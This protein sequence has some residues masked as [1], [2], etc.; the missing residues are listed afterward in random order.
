MDL[1]AGV[2]V[3]TSGVRLCLIDAEGTLVFKA[4][5]PL[6]KGR[7][8]G[9]RHEQDP[10]A[11]WLALSALL[12]AIPEDKA[13]QI[14]ALSLDGTSGSL[15]LADEQG[16]PLGPTLMYNDARATVEAKSIASHAPRESGAHGA[17]SSL[18]RLLWLMEHTD[19]SEVRYALHQADWLL[20]KLAGAY[21][22]SDENNCLKLG[23]DPVQRQWPEWINELGISTEWLPRVEEPGTA[24]GT[25]DAQIAADLG[26]PHDVKICTGTTDSIA[27]F[28]AT[29]A[30]AIGDAVTSLG[31]TLAIKVLSDRPV[32]APEYGVYSH[33]LWDRWLVGGASNSGGAVLLQHFT[34]EQMQALTEHLV[35]EIPSGLD[36]YPLPSKG[37]RFPVSDPELEPRLEPRPDV[38][39]RFFQ[40]LLE[41]IAHIEQQAYQKLHE[42]GAP[43]PHSLRT[44]GG[45]SHNPAWTQI[46]QQLLQIPFTQPQQEDAAYGAA[47]LARRGIMRPA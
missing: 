4:T 9:P 31:S 10:N 40:G 7:Q 15:L 29:G 34:P 22:F 3:G 8:D 43:W 26:L 46:R 11:W 17:S 13:Q 36:Y 12:K 28:L 23:Y 27:A 5:I 45:G 32:F 41:G 35:P 14:R 37:E 24:I 1:Y 47:L 25:I 6:P 30:S 2:D 33:R 16:Q 39:A 38:E 44:V 42:L 19:T 21:G 20:G 18:A